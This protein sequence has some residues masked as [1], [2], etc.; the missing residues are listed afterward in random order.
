MKVPI[1][2]RFLGSSAAA[3]AALLLLTS[4]TSAG[5]DHED[6][7]PS[8]EPNSPQIILQEFEDVEPG[9]SFEGD[10]A[11]VTGAENAASIN[12]R[13]YDRILQDYQTVHGSCS[14]IADGDTIGSYVISPEA[15]TTLANEA[16]VS[17]MFQIESACANGRIS[18]SW[19]SFTTTPDT[20]VEIY[21]TDFL[22][23]SK[24]K[25]YDIIAL[26]TLGFAETTQDCVEDFTNALQDRLSD[27]DFTAWNSVFKFAV[28]AEG[29]KLGISQ[30][31]IAP[32][33]CSA[34]SSIIPWSSL[35]GRLSEFGENLSASVQ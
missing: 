16:L 4:C 3:S 13:I 29:I 6:A 33:A 35:E 7:D 18:T 20:A 1:V 10:I 19:I 27:E 21:F 11:V 5:S 15:S 31:S 23:A 28:T 17:V 24:A 8:T 12:S 30:G 34:G 14:I 22:D 25:A 26:I 9:L 32:N 2:S